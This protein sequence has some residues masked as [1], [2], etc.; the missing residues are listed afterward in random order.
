MKIHKLLAKKI[1][2]DYSKKRSRKNVKYIVI[3]YT[4]NN[5]DTAKNN[6][7]YFLLRFLL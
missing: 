7:T 3:H 1:S 4:G 5:G 6:A 2:Y